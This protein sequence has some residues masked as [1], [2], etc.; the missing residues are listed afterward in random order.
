MLH[1]GQEVE[2]IGP[3]KKDYHPNDPRMARVT[4][5]PIFGQIYTIRE[6]RQILTDTCPCVLLNGLCCGFNAEGIEYGLPED[7]VRPIQKKKD[8]TFWTTG[9]PKDSKKFDNRRKVKEKA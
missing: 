9:A 3:A 6:L 2:F 7:W 1:V 4:N 5:W 8:E